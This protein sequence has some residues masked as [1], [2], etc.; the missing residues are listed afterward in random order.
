MLYAAALILT[1]IALTTYLAPGLYARYRSAV[2]DHD[3]ARV[4]LFLV[5]ADLDRDS[6][7]IGAGDSPE[8]D[9][10]GISD[11][12]SASIPFYITSRA[13]V[14]VGYSVTVDFGGALPNYL[15]VTLSD[16]TNSETI[17][18]D[19]TKSV[20]AFEKFGA[21]DAYAGSASDPADRIDFTLVLNVTDSDLITSEFHLPS[22][23][24]YVT[25]EQ[26]D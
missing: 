11:I 5:G 6:L 13:E 15:T 4:A 14:A 23:R 17:A 1:V 24:L 3:G 22:A 18:G 19:G 7:S 12:T 21:I 25:A 2:E 9:L 26:L 10:G 8:F 16:G 20:F